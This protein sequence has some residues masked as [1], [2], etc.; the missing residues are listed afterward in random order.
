MF[1]DWPKVMNLIIALSMSV[2]TLSL[3][4]YPENWADCVNTFS[5]LSPL[6]AINLIFGGVVFLV[7]LMLMG[8]FIY[9][10]ILCLKRRISE[11]HVQNV[12]D[13]SN[14][15][16]QRIVLDRAVKTLPSEEISFELDLTQKERIEDSLE[17]K[18]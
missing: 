9:G 2:V 12:D 6:G 3:V 4:T 8:L 1:S 15:L 14:P 17:L 7:V 10:G 11:H 18:F 13:K 16:Y 5:I